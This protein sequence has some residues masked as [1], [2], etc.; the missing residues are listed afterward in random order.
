MKIMIIVI[1]W[2][3]SYFDKGG[4]GEKNKNSEIISFQKKNSH[5]SGIQLSLNSVPKSFK[6][7]F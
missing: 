3:L 1:E 7:S 6:S 4:F 2:L 5:A